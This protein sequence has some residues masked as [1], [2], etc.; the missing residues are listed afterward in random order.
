MTFVQRR[1]LARVG[2]T[3][4]WLLLAFIVCGVV[5]GQ[6]TP[7]LTT[8]TVTESGPY[9]DRITTLSASVRS[10]AGLVAAGQVEFW[11]NGRRSS[12]S[13]LVGTDPAPNHV[14]G[15]AT[16]KL[17][18]PGGTYSVIAKYSG[19]TAWQ[20][21]S[22]ISQSIS[23]PSLSRAQILLESV[24]K[25]SAPFTLT[26]PEPLNVASGD[27]VLS[28]LTS[29][30]NVGSTKWDTASAA[31]GT[32]QTSYPFAFTPSALVVADL[33]GVGN[34]DLVVGDASS[35]SLE[36]FLGNSG[37]TWF[38]SQTIAVGQ[39]PDAIVVSDLNADGLPDIA[40]VNAGSGTVAVLMQDGLNPGSF[41][42]PTVYQV[43]GM[44]VAIATGDFNHDG[45][46]DLA[47]AD[48]SGNSLLLLLNQ[49]TTPGSFSLGL[50]ISTQGGPSSIAVG[51]FTA[52]GT[53]DLAVANY[54]DNSVSIFPSDPSK[55]AL[56]DSPADVNLVGAGPTSIIAADF[57][58]DGLL[59]L[60]ASNALDGTVSILP[61]LPSYPGSFPTQYVLD[62]FTT[63]IALS[64]VTPLDGGA[65]MDLAVTDAATGNLTILQNDGAGVFNKSS[66]L[67]LGQGLNSPTTI[68]SLSSGAKAIATV[69]ASL[70]SVRV[71]LSTWDVSGTIQPSSGIGTTVPQRFQADAQPAAS[72][73]AVLSN[74]VSSSPSQLTPQTITF[75][76]PLATMYGSKATP[77]VATASSGLPVQ[78]SVSSGP[79]S[80]V[81]ASLTITGAG[82]VIVAANQQGDA[83]FAP[84]STQSRV[85]EVARAP[86]QVDPAPASRD[87]GSANPEFT[88]L[89]SGAVASD[90]VNI[91]YVSSA[92]VL[93]PPGTYLQAPLGISGILSPGIAE[94]NYRVRSS[95]AA[96]TI[97]PAMDPVTSKHPSISPAGPPPASTA[98]TSSQT[99]GTNGVTPIPSTGANTPV[100]SVTP[101]T[102][103]SSSAVTTIGLPT[104]VPTAPFPHPNPPNLGISRIGTLA[105]VVSTAIPPKKDNPS[106]TTV[107]APISWPTM[108]TVLPS[109]LS[110]LGN[111][112]LP[113]PTVVV[114]PQVSTASSLLLLRDGRLPNVSGWV[115]MSIAFHCVAEKSK[116]QDVLISFGSDLQT[117][118]SVT[119]DQEAT[120]W[121]KLPVGSTTVVRAHF[122]GS[123]GCA[124][125]DSQEVAV[126]DVESANVL[127][128]DRIEES[129]IPEL[130]NPDW[131]FT[132][133]SL[134]I[135]E[136]RREHSWEW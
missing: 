54:L 8:I 21:S 19:T 34:D 39:Q 28:D 37:P 122:V 132:A 128:E 9:G 25:A 41:L 104:I 126:T 10:A 116:R 38:H 83:T 43:G 96:L 4:C 95:I 35:G 64:A 129:L 14:S 114:R 56:F 17:A 130:A 49:S 71:A 27:V 121:F 120:Y 72:Q 51:D 42:A 102:T 110:V 106:S 115:A 62:S 89:V 22:S 93:T 108:P 3:L 30:S 20:A 59:D 111:V 68:Y 127:F 6:A 107:V 133:T 97:L 118:F 77:L 84:A 86:L 135:S 50:P 52:R 15:V 85:V 46:V 134:G 136:D 70:R 91:T 69:D 11:L 66:V 87:F 99:A 61:A 57:N 109:L 58:G 12:I 36:I 55:Q 74:I 48:F 78:F 101:P 73:L 88:G 94:Q 7:T 53:C 33:R 124:A 18:L 5:H 113:H 100:L 79:G 119:E 24:S 103:T 13:Q 63:P 75:T 117:V 76:A 80:I 1:R 67:E 98:P 90:S 123:H 65:S 16:A 31:L 92:N 2:R 60:A 125:S 131:P 26:S 44:P 40:V 47:V 45:L 112:A 105:P 29:G 82:K 32:M 81:N 23:V